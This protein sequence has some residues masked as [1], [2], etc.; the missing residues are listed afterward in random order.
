LKGLS[1]PTIVVLL[2]GAIVFLFG[3][4]WNAWLG[5]RSEQAT[6]DA[7]L[8][9]DVT[10]LS[11][12]SSG[13]V[14]SVAVADFQRVK[15][16]DLLVQLKDDDFRAQVDVAGAAVAAAE[17]GL[18][19]LKSQRELQ[20]AKVLQAQAEMAAIKPD[21]E[22][23][24]LALARERALEQAGVSSK[25]NLE[26]AQADWA[27]FKGT[28]RSRGAETDTQR[29]QEGVLNSLEVQLKAEL[30]AKQAALRL[31]TVNLDYTRIVAPTDGVVGERKVRA[32]QL[33]NVGT[34]VI[35]LVGT[36]LWVVANYKEIQLE[37][38]RVGDNADVTVD[39]LSGAQ[40]QGHVAQISPASGAM[41]ALLPP[42]NATGNFTKVAQ[43]VSV[44]IAIDDSQGLGDLLRPGMSVVPTILTD[45]TVASA[46]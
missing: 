32:G 33:V 10:P 41:F 9:A 7:Q 25:Q 15:A 45:Q 5:A 39:G 27:R 17:V 16:G 29:K 23:S 3:S 44:R 42:D 34:Q 38:V 36:S 28:L 6:D 11:T 46:K 8:R 4:R 19:S 43:R 22:R 14:A 18:A 13:I 31:A 40:W 37:H 21:F 24:E 1:T 20:A 35:S 26:I 2:A 12:K 30:A